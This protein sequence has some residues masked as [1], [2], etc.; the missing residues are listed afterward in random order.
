[1]R[2]PWTYIATE[3]RTGV[4]LSSH[5]EGP[6]DANKAVSEFKEKHPDKYLEALVPGTHPC[7]TFETRQKARK[8]YNLGDKRG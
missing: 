6:F 5:F 8:I 3:K 2:R 1:M 7:T 4:R